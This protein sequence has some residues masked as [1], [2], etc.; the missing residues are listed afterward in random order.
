MS[1][2]TQK[3]VD[4][5]NNLANRMKKRA[6]DLAPVEIQWDASGCVE[7]DNT[8]RIRASTFT[9]KGKRYNWESKVEADKWVTDPEFRKQI[10]LRAE[11]EFRDMAD[12][13]GTTLAVKQVF[14]SDQR[15]TVRFVP[16][17]PPG[18][19]DLTLEIINRAMN[20]LTENNVPTSAR[21][22]LYDQMLAQ[23]LV[24]RQAVALPQKSVNNRDAILSISIDGTVT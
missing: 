5:A 10:M 18:S 13:E 4:D 21:K 15:A 16:S 6:A 20:T 19:G 24:V 17:L 7:Y 2:A 9:A 1:G 23:Q 3:L 11:R 22:D 12:A 14:E 8:L